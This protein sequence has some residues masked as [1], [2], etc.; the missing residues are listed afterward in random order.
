MVPIAQHKVKICTVTSKNNTANWCLLFTIKHY[1]YTTIVAFM[2]MIV[3]NSLVRQKE[4]AQGEEDE[5]AGD[6]RSGGQGCRC[7]EQEKTWAMKWGSTPQDGSYPLTIGME[8]D[9]EG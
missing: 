3:P 5:E 1:G 7:G 8:G 4:V 9:T 2:M 6:R